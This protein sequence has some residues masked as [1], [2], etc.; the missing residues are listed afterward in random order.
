[1][2]QIFFVVRTEE[3]LCKSSSQ[4]EVNLHCTLCPP[5]KWTMELGGF[6]KRFARLWPR[7]PLEK[8][9][10]TLF[11]CEDDH[12]FTSAYDAKGLV[13]CIAEAERLGAD[14]LSLA[15]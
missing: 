6:G 9:A 1:M 8:T 3:P 5:L 14:V 4:G 7:K 12:V 13:S 2:Q 10:V 11:F 15:V